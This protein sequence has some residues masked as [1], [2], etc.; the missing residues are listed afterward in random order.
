M[1]YTFKLTF[2]V[3]A[4]RNNT[5]NGDIIFLGKIA[6]IIFEALTH[7]CSLNELE[8]VRHVQTLKNKLSSL[9][10]NLSSPAGNSSH[11]LL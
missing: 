8:H 4:L 10:F 9:F 6:A 11:T 2:N 7:N 1:Y 3:P 5:E